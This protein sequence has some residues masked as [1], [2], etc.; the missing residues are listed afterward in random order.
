MVSWSLG[1]ERMDWKPCT[2]RTALVVRYAFNQE[3]TK[4]TYNMLSSHFVNRDRT[5]SYLCRKISG[6]IRLSNLV[7]IY[8]SEV[9]PFI[10]WKKS[11]VQLKC[12]GFYIP[13]TRSRHHVRIYKCICNI[14][15]HICLSGWLSVV[16]VTL[17]A[18]T[19]MEINK[20][21][22]LFLVG[23]TWCFFL[24][25]IIDAFTSRAHASPCAK[26]IH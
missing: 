3:K 25:D 19:L 21:D 1:T 9:V 13:C 11:L 15:K 12:E 7:S 17:R 6:D 22:Q 14:L 23:T 2:N 5:N 18:I 20:H 4:R 8:T 26:E 10:F 16:M 24:E